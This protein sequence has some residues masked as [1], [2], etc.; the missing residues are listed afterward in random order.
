MIELLASLEKI[1]VELRQKKSEA[2]KLRKKA[3]EQLKQVRSTGRRSVSGLNS[4]DKKIE[5]EQEDVSDVSGILVQKNSQLESIERLVQAAEERLTREKDEIEQTKQEI[6]FSENPEE[7]Q[8]AE[9]RLR[10]LLEHVEELVSEIKSRKKT[11]KK[12]T[13]DAAQYSDIKSKINT[14]IQTQSKTK[15]TLR[16]TI[17]SSHKTAEKLVKELD[18]R[19]KVEES[20]K[21]LLD[22]SLTKLKELLAKKKTAAKKKVVKR[23]PAKKTAAKKKVVKRKPAKKV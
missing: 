10:S 21:K 15:P 11:A 5:S 22:R 23:K 4:I 2:T 3:E 14:K 18:K 12:I 8:Y 13:T 16:E 19:I 17:S 9:S 1:V 6:E 7:K 20:T